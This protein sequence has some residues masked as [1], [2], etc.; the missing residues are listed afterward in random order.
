MPPDHRKPPAPGR[1]P[2]T[3]ANTAITRQDIDRQLADAGMHPRGTEDS[4]AAALTR[5]E[6]KLLID[7]VRRRSGEHRQRFASINEEAEALKAQL[8]EATKEVATE[9]AANIQQA[10]VDVSQQMQKDALA[11][12][13]TLRR[14]WKIALV[15]G[16]FAV[17]AGA[18]CGAAVFGYVSASR[19]AADQ[20]QGVATETAKKVV[21][22]VALTAPPAPAPA[23]TERI[24]YV[25]APFAPAP[26]PAMD[27]GL[28]DR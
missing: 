8:A 19:A 13:A 4:A 9:A 14:W 28:G 23:V 26:I 18:S 25:P 16:G 15:V 11:A 17:T 12:A 5:E 21:E 22:E 6:Q 7:Y 20:T 1:Y 10:G 3:G 27:A 2:D 24:Y